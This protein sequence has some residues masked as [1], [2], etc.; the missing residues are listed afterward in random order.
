L[1][2]IKACFTIVFMALD[3]STLDSET[4]R[5][6]DGRRYPEHLRPYEAYDAEFLRRLAQ[7][8]EASANEIALS[9]D[10][11]RLRSL[12][13]RWLASAEWRGLIERHDDGV[14]GRRTYAVTERGRRRL[15][16]LASA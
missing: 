7:I 11:P 2:A 8:G 10:S 4:P 3:R 14:A 13:S 12:V 16:D 15:D 1:L 9:I 5:T 6:L